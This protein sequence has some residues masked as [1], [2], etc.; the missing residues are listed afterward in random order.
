MTLVEVLV[1]MAI[2]FIIFLGMSSGGIV[3]LDQNIKNS[4]RDEA[5]NVAEMELQ[6]VR[7]TPFDNIV[8]DTTPRHVLRQIRGLNMDYTVNRTV[9]LLDAQNK[10]VTDNVSWSR[11]E[12][13]AQKVYFHQVMTIVRSN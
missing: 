4:Q 9:V 1:A 5:V 11:L 6:Q 12:N 10:Q 2:I 13:N 8:S 3:V 7:N